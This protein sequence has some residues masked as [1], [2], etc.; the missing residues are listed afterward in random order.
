VT[1]DSLAGGKLLI[2]CSCSKWQTE[3]RK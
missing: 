3:T 2:S 1:D